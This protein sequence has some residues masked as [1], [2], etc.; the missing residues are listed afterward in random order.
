MNHYTSLFFTDEGYFIYD[1]LLDLQPG[2]WQGG[3]VSKEASC[4]KKVMESCMLNVPI[5]ILACQ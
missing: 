3:Y 2:S 1:D 4:Y 5:F